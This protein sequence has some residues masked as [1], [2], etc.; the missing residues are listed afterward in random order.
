MDINELWHSGCEQYWE[1]ALSEYDKIDSAKRNFELEK[2]M[3]S[4]D[5]ASVK[6]M[7]GQQFYCFLYDEYFV[8]KYTAKNRL[9]TTRKHLQKHEY[10]LAG[11]E[12]IHADIF[13][14]FELD[15][16]DTKKLLCKTQQIHGLGT[17]GA[18]GLLSILFPEYYGTVDQFVVKSLCKIEDLPEKTKIENMNSKSLT[19]KDGVIIESI[20][21]LKSAELNDKFNKKEWIPRKIDMI[22]WAFREEK[23]NNK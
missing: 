22:L 23:K 6:E 8:W 17:A 20:F 3:S 15:P 9:A 5:P 4:I 7:N 10:N 18:S 21:R 14:L 2:R 11:L 19:M 12:K 1:D 13:N 16:E